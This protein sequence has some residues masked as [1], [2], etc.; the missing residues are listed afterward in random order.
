MEDFIAKKIDFRFRSRP[1]VFMTTLLSAEALRAARALVGL[2]QR[3]AA[4]EASMTQK[5]VWIA[6]SDTRLGISANTK[7]KTFYEKAGIEF[8]GT[9]DLATGRTTGLGARWRSPPQLPLLPLTAPDFHPERTGVAFG[10]ARAVLNKKQSEIA[11]LS[12]LTQ[13]KLGFLESGIWIDQPSLLR[14]RSFYEREGITFLGWGDVT[15]GLF[16]GVG[17]RWEAKLLSSPPS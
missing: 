15:S 5:A 4:A 10:A 3:E 2:S 17:V 9:V 16:Y 1:L 8:L 11:D 14:L 12:G 6:E 7:L 13:R